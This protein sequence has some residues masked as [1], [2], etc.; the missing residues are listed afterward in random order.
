MEVRHHLDV[1]PGGGSVGAIS[2][3][4]V[5]R[6]RRRR[7]HVSINRDFIQDAVITERAITSHAQGQRPVNVRN[8]ARHGSR[9]WSA[10]DIDS[11]CVRRRIGA[12]P[13]HYHVIP[14]ARHDRPGPRSQD[15]DGSGAAVGVEPHLPAARLLNE[16]P[17]RT[18]TAD[19]QTA[20]WLFG[21]APG[22]SGEEPALDR[23]A[24]P[25]ATQSEGGL[26]SRDRLACAAIKLRGGVRI[27]AGRQRPGLLIANPRE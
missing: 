8:K 16:R 14:L 10:I 13:G 3:R 15:A 22:I 5:V 9:S 1:S 24:L 20:D 6:D 7:K 23:E 27:T 11:R 17:T 26:I 12:G 2:R 25:A 21:Y 4:E 18:R 19:F